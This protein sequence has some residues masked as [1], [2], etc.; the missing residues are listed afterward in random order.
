MSIHK[1]L[2]ESLISGKIN[3]F[4]GGLNKINDLYEFNDRGFNI[5]HVLII[6]HNKKESMIPY[7]KALINCE[8]DLTIFTKTR[9][10]KKTALHLA[11]ELSHEDIVRLLVSHGVDINILND[12]GQP[13]IFRCG[14]DDD[15]SL[16]EDSAIRTF[17]TFIELGA[18]LNIIDGYGRLMLHNY[19]CGYYGY[20]GDDDYP[21]YCHREYPKFFQ[22][23]LDACLKVGLDPSIRDMHNGTVIYEAK[24]RSHQTY[25][26]MLEKYIELYNEIP[27]IKEPVSV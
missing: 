26:Q 4:I 2:N 5:L 19:A 13:P 11:S 20:R 17:N 9:T 10:N 6:K 25:V 8:Y 18:R 22:V 24:C 21:H 14:C 16:K 27:V 15:A 12:Q 23:V 7:I 3:K 1:L